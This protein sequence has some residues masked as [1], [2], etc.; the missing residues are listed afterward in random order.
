MN[1]TG[2]PALGAPR[3]VDGKAIGVA[4]AEAVGSRRRAGPAGDLGEDVVHEREQAGGGAK[5]HRDGPPGTS[6]G[7]QLLHE[8]S[9]LVQQRHVRVPESVDRLLPVADDEDGRLDGAVPRAQPLAP[10]PHEQRHELPLRA[11]G[12]LHLVDEHVLVA[13][14]QFEAA[15]RELLH[16]PQQVERA[17]EHLRVV[18]HGVLVERAAVLGDGDLEE[19]AQSARED[20]V[21]VAAEGAQALGHGRRHGLDRRAVPLPGV[22]RPALVRPEPRPAEPARAARPPLER[23]VVR[24]HAI[25]ECAKR[26]LRVPRVERGLPGEQAGQV[27]G[28][29]RER[30]A[31]EG[32]VGD[33]RVEASRRRGQRVA[34]AHGRLAARRRGRQPARA[35]GQEPAEHVAGY[36]AAADQR[37][38]ART[39]PALA[40][41]H[42]HHRDVLVLPRQSAADPQGPVQGLVHE[43]RHLGLV[44]E[45]E[46]GIRAGLERELADEREAEGVDRRDRDVGQPP[47]Q[48]APARLVERRQRAGLLQPRDDALAHLG[49]GLA[50]ERDRQDRVRIDARAKQVDVAVDEHAGLARAGR[51]LEHDV[52]G[53]V[54]GVPARLGIRQ[55]GVD[56]EREAHLAAIRHRPRSPSGRRRRSCRSCTGTRRSASAGSVPPR[57]R[58]RPSGT[59]P[60][61]RRAPCRDPTAP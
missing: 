25:G 47:A 36:E 39:Q 42:E 7:P 49:R 24:A 3:L 57:R 27:G 10:A 1:P 13:R 48:L 5:A 19:P 12:V 17:G 35:G 31:A 21:Q 28:E 51:R 18:E 30:R 37:R 60:A 15:A 40:E 6:A 54:D 32:A 14:L 38:E 2:D 44:G 9:R 50:R 20:D 8:A 58:R 41:L 29:H 11:V 53:G 59:A 46:P 34:Q 22:R 52:L 43:P 55:L 45:L 33:E 16:L 23:Q 56:V 26:R 4:V 61:P